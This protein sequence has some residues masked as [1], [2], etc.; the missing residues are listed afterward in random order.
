[1][2]NKDKNKE[3]IIKRNWYLKNKEKILLKKN[4]WYLINKEKILEE[5]KQYY[6][7]N[8][9][10]ILK[11]QYEYIFKNRKIR[12]LA[13]KKRYYKKMKDPSFRVIQSIRARVRGILRSTHKSKSSFK[14]LGVPDIE[15]F[16]KHLEK[17][18]KPGMTRENYGLW[19]VDHIKAVSTFDRTDPK[20]IQI[21]FNYKNCQP[22]WSLEN[23]KKGNK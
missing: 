8:K 4:N 12:N 23:K 18:F 19:E 11:Q 5:K 9:E 7:I 14:Y 21:C 3:K 2:P 10:K 6:L 1:M 17:L 15:F 13:A 22:M 20:Q 16:W